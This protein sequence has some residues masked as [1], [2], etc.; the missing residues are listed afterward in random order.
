MLL[1]NVIFFRKCEL[2]F[3]TNLTR[4]YYHECFVCGIVKTLNCLQKL[5]IEYGKRNLYDDENQKQIYNNFLE[6]HPFE[7]SQKFPINIDDVTC[8]E[9]QIGLVDPNY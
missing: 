8:V 6:K 7:N 2:I 5:K 9:S 4:S 1:N 3:P